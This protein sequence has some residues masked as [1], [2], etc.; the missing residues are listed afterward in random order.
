MR[1][2]MHGATSGVG[3]SLDF[4]NTVCPHCGALLNVAE[5]RPVACQRCQRSDVALYTYRDYGQSTILCRDC[6]EHKLS[7][8]KVGPSEVKHG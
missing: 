2:P 5:M 7:F 8:V 3:I 4:A 1:V 6:I